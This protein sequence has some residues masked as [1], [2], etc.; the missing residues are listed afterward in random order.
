MRING[1]QYDRYTREE[2]LR[3]ARNLNIASVSEKSKLE[4][5]AQE[6]KKTVKNFFNQPDLVVNGQ[7]VV[8]M[9]N[10]RV[11]RGNRARQW[12]TIGQT[13]QNSLARAYL[14]ESNY[15]YW[16]GLIPRDK[17]IA[18]LA[19]K[20][21]R[22]VEAVNSAKAAS[23]STNSSS[24]NTLEFELALM[25]QGALP[26]AKNENVSALEKLLTNLP[27]GARG[28]PLKPNVNRVIKNFKNQILR[29]NQLATVK[30]TYL[31]S[32]KVPNWL[33]ANKVQ[34]YKNHLMSVSSL[35]KRR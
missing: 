31:A 23:A 11:K 34:A 26:N 33:P 27:R 18:I 28:K 19:H 17:Y 4:N 14:P 6:I 5:I 25:A 16:Q 20:G 2:L 1:K 29:R 24:P 3:V 22:K 32:I 10:G 35:L 15:A 8:F 13:E 21:E 30:A 12:V 9:P 7:P